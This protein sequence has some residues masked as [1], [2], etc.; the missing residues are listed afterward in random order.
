MALL[1]GMPGPL[2][3]VLLRF[4]S[5]WLRLTHLLATDLEFTVKWVIWYEPMKIL[6]ANSV[7]ILSCY[8][9]SKMVFFFI[10]WELIS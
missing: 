2:A 7:Q 1:R 10:I 6:Q 5:I 8:F 4:L 3:P 9:Y